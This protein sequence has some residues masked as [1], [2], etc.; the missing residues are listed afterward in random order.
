MTINIT[1]VNINDDSTSL[2]RSTSTQGGGLANK[3]GLAISRILSSSSRIDETDD[4]VADLV[5][6]VTE[7]NHHSELA[8]KLSSTNKISKILGEV[9]ETPEKDLMSEIQ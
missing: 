7:L 3:I 5:S 6:L 2:N 4:D 1:S 9:K 8:V